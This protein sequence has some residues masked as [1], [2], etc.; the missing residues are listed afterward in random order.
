MKVVQ[1]ANRQLRIPDD[2]LEYYLRLGYRE[3]RKPPAPK[4]KNKH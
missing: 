2:K 3:I 4:P 1:K